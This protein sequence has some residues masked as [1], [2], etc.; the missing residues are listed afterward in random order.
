WIKFYSTDWVIASLNST[1]SNNPIDTWYSTWHDT[2]L[3]ES[4]HA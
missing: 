1:F 2:N 4:S 3:A